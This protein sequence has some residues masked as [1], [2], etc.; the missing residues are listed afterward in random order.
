MAK[1]N[2]N[3]GVPPPVT[4]DIK[5][6]KDDDGKFLCWADIT[7]YD[8]CENAPHEPRNYLIRLGDQRRGK[9]LHAMANWSGWRKAIRELPRGKLVEWSYGDGR[10]ARVVAVDAD[11]N[12]LQWLLVRDADA[13]TAWSDTRE[14]GTV[15]DVSDAETVAS[16]CAIVTARRMT[17]E[18]VSNKPVAL[19]TEGTEVTRG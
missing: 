10:K 14:G 7:D 12:P 6:V 16:A 8:A 13:C 18:I 1:R 17:I 2:R 9:R 4:V 3:N 15:F 19:L 5:W 11:G